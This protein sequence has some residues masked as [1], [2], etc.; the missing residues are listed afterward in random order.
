MREAVGALVATGVLETRPGSGTYVTDLSPETVA[1]PLAFMLDAGH[2]SSL[3]LFEVRLLLEVAAAKWAAVRI[4]ADALDLL[5]QEVC[6]LETWIEDIERFTDADI[7]F[8][9]LIHEQTGNAILLELMS[10]ISVL[11]RGTRVV[12]SQSRDAR[13]ETIPEHRNILGNLQARDPE[14]A[15][16]AMSRHLTKCWSHMTQAG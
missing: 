5:E 7:A 1:G 12:L 3:D 2:R 9:R 8:H 11:D 10:S 6:A 15:A 13:E 4:D 14:A 16:R